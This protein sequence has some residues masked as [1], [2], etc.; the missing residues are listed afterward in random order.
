[1][2]GTFDITVDGDLFKAAIT[3]PQYADENSKAIEQTDA[4]DE[5]EYEIEELEPGEQ[6]D[7]E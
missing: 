7:E 4:A 3:F 6:T 5:T 2:G 1:M